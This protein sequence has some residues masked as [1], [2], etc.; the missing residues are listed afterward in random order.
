MD[1]TKTKNAFDALYDFEKN[2]VGFPKGALLGMDCLITKTNIMSK[3]EIEVGYFISVLDK[4]VKTTF[5]KCD[6]GDKEITVS[7]SSRFIKIYESSYIG[8]PQCIKK[9]CRTHTDS[10]ARFICEYLNK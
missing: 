2:H 10:A 5:R 9:V 6:K 7:V 1:T 4:A 8:V 3:R